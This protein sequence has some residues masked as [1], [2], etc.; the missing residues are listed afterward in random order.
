MLP[1]NHILNHV[2]MK[3]VRQYLT[4]AVAGLIGVIINTNTLSAKED[5]L[6]R[7]NGKEITKLDMKRAEIEM[8]NQLVNVPKNARRKVLIE[9]L[10]ETQ[11]LA[12]A[13]S[14]AK[15]DETD[16][17]KNRLSYYHRRAMRDT[18]FESQV[19]GAVKKED[20]KKT[21]EEAGKEQEAH[22]QH[23][24]VKEESLAKELSAKLAKGGEFGALA[25]QHSID[26]GSKNK[27]G[28]LGFIVKTQVVPAFGEAAFSL[29]KKGEISK[30]VKSQFGWHLIRLVEK[31][32][33]PLPPFASVE[34]R[35]KEVL[36]QKKAETLI[37]TLRKEAKVEF[38]DK[39][40]EKPL[41][42]PRGS[43]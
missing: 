24:L 19:F 2:G 33:R 15:V 16:S 1:P 35:I 14:K 10:I 41:E 40:L 21:Y 30:P 26:P 7:V 4:I 39:E 22:V 34:E 28:D 5:V 11:L 12:N 29:T 18:Y 32:N 20:I 9:Y 17:Y 8:F 13:A 25:K 43:N 38:I 42:Q 31:R 6:A 37:E 3:I 23:I 27:A 36:W